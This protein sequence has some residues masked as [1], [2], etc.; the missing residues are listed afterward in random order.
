MSSGRWPTL[1]QAG[2]VISANLSRGSLSFHHQQKGVPMKAAWEIFDYEV[3]QLNELWKHFQ[4]GNHNVQPPEI[5]NAMAESAIIH[6]RIALEMLRDDRQ[7]PDDYCLTDLIA[8]SDKPAALPAL[9]QMYTDDATYG[10]L[11]VALFGDNPGTNMT[12]NP[13]WQIDK[14]MFHPTNNR[15]TTHDWTPILNIL[16]PQIGLVIADLRQHAVR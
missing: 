9:I 10:P 16:A 4:A 7:K 8:T 2:V 5:R 11:A 14:L 13:K 1:E 3:M 12:K 15:T 6:L